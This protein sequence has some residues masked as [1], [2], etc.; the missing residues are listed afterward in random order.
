MHLRLKRGDRITYGH[1]MWAENNYR[2]RSWR[3]GTVIA[4][5]ERGGIKVQ[6]ESGFKLWVPYHH[7]GWI[8]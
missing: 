1:S 4:V 7:V 8:D 5:T 2:S 6:D 3:H